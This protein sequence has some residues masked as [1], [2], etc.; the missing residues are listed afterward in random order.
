MKGLFEAL[1]D[2]YSVLSR[3][4]HAER[5]DRHHLGPVR[6]G[7]PLYRQAGQGSQ[8][9]RRRA[10]VYRDRV[11]DRG[12]AGRQVRARVRRPHHQ[13]RRRGHRSAE[14]LPGPAEDPG[15]R[16]AARSPSPSAGARPISTRALVRAI[17]EIPTVKSALIPT[18]TGNIAYLRIIE[19]TAATESAFDD[20]IKSFDKAG[21]RALI[22]DVR[23]D[24]GGLLQAVIGISD[25]LL[26]SGVIVSTKGRNPF[27]NS[28]QPRRRPTSSCPRTSPSSSSSTRA[29]PRPPRSSP[30]PSRTTSAPTSS[31]RIPTARA[32]SS[33]STR[34]TRPATR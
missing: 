34:S 1:G 11:A 19:F 6:G 10:S 15:R 25:D 27:E 16:W 7:R 4:D 20:A 5:H 3:R 12:Y 13:D 30:A 8:E 21:Y 32:R 29:R 9:A 28:R 31:A 14:L 2:P 22:I 24:G 26:D 18:P 23:N 17:I 33:R